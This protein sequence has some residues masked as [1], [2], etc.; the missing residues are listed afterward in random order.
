MH[1]GLDEST[2][3]Y[4]GAIFAPAD[5][6]V[7]AAGYGLG[8]FNNSAGWRI[9]AHTVDGLWTFTFNHMQYGSLLVAAGDT[10]SRGVQ[11]GTEGGTGNVTGRHLHIET[12]E[13]THNNPWPPPYGPTPVDP[14]PVFAAHGVTIA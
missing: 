10:V 11:I 2:P 6:I 12:Y 7:T 1:W 4:A 5:M 9:V 13:G 8:S 3:G 14:L